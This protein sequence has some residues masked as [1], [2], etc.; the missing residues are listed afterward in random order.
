M[1]ICIEGFSLYLLY[2][3]DI[4][5]FQFGVWQL[6]PLILVSS[7]FPPPPQSVA[8][9]HLHAPKCYIHFHLTVSQVSRHR[10]QLFSFIA[11]SIASLVLT[12]YHIKA[13]PKLVIPEYSEELLKRTNMFSQIR[14]KLFAWD[15]IKNECL[16]G[17]VKG[18]LRYQI[19]DSC[20]DGREK[21]VKIAKKR[22]AVTVTSGAYARYR[23]SKG[24]NSAPLK[25]YRL[26]PKVSLI[27]HPLLCVA[28]WQS[29]GVT[30]GWLW[31]G[32]RRNYSNK[33]FFTKD[34]T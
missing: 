20:I 23:K 28:D 18:N 27:S 1:V 32:A 7:P 8:K 17:A 14:R 11:V 24:N 9:C 2:R 25:L 30:K 15:R 31:G 29:S 34:E 10:F 3:D 21:A 22:L 13:N 26:A 6:P 5:W 4:Q 19:K 33:N 12:I 16:S